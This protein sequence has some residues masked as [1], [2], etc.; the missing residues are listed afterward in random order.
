[1]Y[2]GNAA[3]D[4]PSQSV[5]VLIIRRPILHRLSKEVHQWICML[6]SDVCHLCDGYDFCSVEMLRAYQ[7]IFRL[8]LS[9]MK[10]TAC[11]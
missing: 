8:T 11:G 9:E 10:F 3:S 2:F 7:I 1:M 5:S 6:L 4:I